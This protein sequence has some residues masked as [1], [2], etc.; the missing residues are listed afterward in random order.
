[1]SVKR[2]VG[3]THFTI[4]L[5]FKLTFKIMVITSFIAEEKIEVGFFVTIDLGFPYLT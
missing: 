1:M 4:H 2:I 5:Q 3:H